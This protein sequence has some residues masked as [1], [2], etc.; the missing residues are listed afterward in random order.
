MPS[1]F[2]GTQGEKHEGLGV[3][4]TKRK[5]L[6]HHLL[7]QPWP[8][9]LRPVGSIFL[10]FKTRIKITALSYSQNHLRIKMKSNIVVT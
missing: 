4:R 5:F 10:L 3:Q 2:N 9:H 1:L 7:V 8:S 6:L